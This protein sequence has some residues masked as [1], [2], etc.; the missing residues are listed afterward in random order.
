MQV[1]QAT[2]RDL[3]GGSISEVAEISK[4]RWIKPQKSTC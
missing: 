1:N 2:E 3:V 4:W